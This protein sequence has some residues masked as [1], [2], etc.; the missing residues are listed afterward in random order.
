MPFSFES[1]CNMTQITIIL[2]S[3][4]NPFQDIS[5]QNPSTAQNLE[6]CNTGIFIKEV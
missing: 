4:Q 1:V 6:T 3:T 5:F 2:P